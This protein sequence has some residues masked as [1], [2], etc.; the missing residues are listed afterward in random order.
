MKKS[1]IA[2]AAVAA[3]GV[4]GAAM[5]GPSWTY[6]DLG[7]TSGASFE[8]GSDGGDTD[9]FALRGSFGIDIWHARLEYNDGEVLGGK[10]SG[11]ADTDGYVLAVGAHPAITDNTDLVL[12]L[13]YFDQETDF[14]FGEADADGY[15]LTVGI[16]SMF[17]DNVELS[18]G[19]TAISGDGATSDAFFFGGD[20]DFKSIAVN[21][22]G[23]Y[24]FTDNVGVGVDVGVA[25]GVLGNSAN[26]YVRWSF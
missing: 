10:N 1:M 26:F 4:S 12:E 21:A 23:Q 2:L 18:A 5:A 15:G 14:G 16:R 19:V 3:T 6:L 24:L 17:T 20:G 9:G 13:S 8:D 11:G 25:S 7:Y 22:G